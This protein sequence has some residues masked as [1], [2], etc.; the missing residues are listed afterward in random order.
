MLVYILQRI[1]PAFVKEFRG[2]IPNEVILR[3][4]RGKHCHVGLEK[5][6]RD[7]LIKNGWQ[8][9]VRDHSVALGD[10][11]VFSYNGN[12]LFDVSIFGRSGCRKDEI[13]DTILVKKE[14]GE[15]ET[16]DELT[17]PPLRKKQMPIEFRLDRAENSG[18]WLFK[19]GIYLLSFSFSIFV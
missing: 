13:S 12:A 2:N 1:P 16:E 7:V 15:E 8:E 9:F 14:E 4:V 10:F 11:L 18:G 17:N 5:V 3:D 19:F 6:E